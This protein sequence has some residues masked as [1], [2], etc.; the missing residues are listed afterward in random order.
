MSSSYHSVPPPSDLPVLKPSISVLNQNFL[1][2]IKQTSAQSFGVSVAC[3][4]DYDGAWLGVGYSFYKNGEELNV[5][6]FGSYT[7]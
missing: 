3:T 1:P 2:Y 5:Q 6:G 7:M 4:P